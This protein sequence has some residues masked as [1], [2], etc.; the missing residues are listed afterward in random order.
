[1]EIYEFYP[2]KLESGRQRREI[3]YKLISSKIGL[4]PVIINLILDFLRPIFRGKMVHIKNGNNQHIRNSNNDFNDKGKPIDLVSEV[5]QEEYQE[6]IYN[7]LI[8]QTLG[9]H[10]W[11]LFVFNYIMYSSLIGVNLHIPKI[12]VLNDHNVGVINNNNIIISDKMLDKSCYKLDDD[13]D[14][15]FKNNLSCFIN[16]NFMIRVV[17]GNLGDGYS[18]KFCGDNCTLKDSKSDDDNGSENNNA[19][20]SHFE[21]NNNGS[22]S[23]FE[24]GLGEFNTWSGDQNLDNNKYNIQDQRSNTLPDLS[25]VKHSNTDSVADEHD[26]LDLDF[27]ADKLV[28][29]HFDKNGRIHNKY[30]ISTLPSNLVIKA[31]CPTKLEF[32]VALVV[33]NRHIPTKATLYTCVYRIRKFVLEKLREIGDDIRSDVI[34]IESIDS[35]L[36]FVSA[37]NTLGYL[38]ASIYDYFT[39]E[40]IFK[41]GNRYKN[42]F[43]DDCFNYNCFND[44]WFNDNYN[45]IINVGLFRY[46]PQ[47]DLFFNFICEDYD[48]NDDENDKESK[49]N[50]RKKY[51]CNKDRNNENDRNK[52]AIRFY[53]RYDF[54]IASSFSVPSSSMIKRIDILVGGGILCL[55]DNNNIMLLI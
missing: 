46:H 3:V 7:Q 5:M 30:I 2:Y 44:D 12:Q 1:M 15:H 48:E 49:T 24:D 29:I 10:S 23:E 36:L 54:S 17:S 9:I 22:G 4:K 33:F 16:E 52:L 39:N 40:I 38:R 8:N 20:G 14:S 28:L 26:N 50:K 51:K 47:L 27:N 42:S 31:I 13:Q 45:E 43:N 21:E 11:N 55:D 6:E 25:N 53:R 32:G 41:L 18:Y 37:E 35:T 34:H 19:S